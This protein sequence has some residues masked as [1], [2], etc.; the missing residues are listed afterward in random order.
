MK[1]SE[2]ICPKCGI[3]L[4]KDNFLVMAFLKNN[5][6]Y[7][8]PECGYEWEKIEKDPKNRKQEE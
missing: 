5:Q 3:E 7:W 4:S 6:K 1:Y 8:C 2:I